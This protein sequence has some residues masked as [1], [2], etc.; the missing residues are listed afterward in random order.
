[1]GVNR[2]NVNSTDS[3]YTHSIFDISEYTGRSYDALSDALADVPEGKRNGG[4]TIRYIIN[5]K[6]VQYRLMSDNWSSNT[7]NWINVDDVLK[8]SIASE[9]GA[10]IYQSNFTYINLLG[11]YILVVTNRHILY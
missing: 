1:M 3:K 5:N 9:F 6:Y 2:I 11:D 8:A 7:D 10:D 4:M